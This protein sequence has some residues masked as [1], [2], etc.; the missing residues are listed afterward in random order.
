MSWK[1]TFVATGFLRMA[2][3]T[4]W[5]NPTNFIPDRLDVIA[6]EIDILGSGVMGLTLKCARCHTH[7][8]DPIPHRDYHRLIAT[9]KGA[10]DEH[11][12]LRS[13]WEPA[14]SKGRRADRELNF[15]TTAE[16]RQWETH[17]ADLQRRIGTLK[18]RLKHEDK[19]HA[20]ATRNEIAALQKEILPEPTI[21]ALW[22]RGEPSPT[23]LYRRGDYLSPGRLVGPGV[24]AVLTDGKT[25]FDVSPHPGQEHPRRAVAWPHGAVADQSPIIRSIPRA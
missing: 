24:P 5:A 10:Y 20:D 1:T 19:S 18:E 25:P 7:K 12:W 9:L 6:D 16:R 15:V 2:P 8:F 23:Y 11:D 21:R 4:T 13:N 17:N 14:I 22:D 3:D